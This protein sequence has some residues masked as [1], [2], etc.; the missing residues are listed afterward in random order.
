A[1]LDWEMATLG[2]REM[3]LGWMAF[4]HRFFE[5]IAGLA[6]LPG[7]PDFLR[8]PDLAHTYAEITG[9]APHDL[10]FYVTYAALRQA[11]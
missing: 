5:D 6:N 8:L 1:V 4:L 10:E 7:L 2:P 3:D 9:H 11:V